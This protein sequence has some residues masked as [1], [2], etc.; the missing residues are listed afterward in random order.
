MKQPDDITL[1]TYSDDRPTTRRARAGS[2]G[3][4]GDDMGL[5]EVEEAGS[6][7]V[8][9]LNDEGQYF[10]AQI[11]NAVE[12]A[13]D[14]DVSELHTRESLEDDVPDEYTGKDPNVNTD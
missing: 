6:E 11:V 3:Q 10:E 14:P 9:E 8:A 5:S 1:R 13:P 7:S 4:S 12:N 2:A